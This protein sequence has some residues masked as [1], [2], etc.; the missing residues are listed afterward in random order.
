MNK[1]ALAFRNWK[2]KLEILPGDLALY[3][4]CK[5]LCNSINSSAHLV[6]LY[7]LYIL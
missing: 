3:I 7:G 6:N 2:H 1:S 4:K 5:L